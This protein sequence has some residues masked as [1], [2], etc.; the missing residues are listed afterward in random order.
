MNLINIEVVYATPEKQK[1]VAIKVEQGTTVRAAAMASG[2][3]AEFEGLDLSKAPLGIYGK[4]VKKPE[5]QEIK[6][7]ERIEVYRP[8]IADPKAA[9]LKRAAK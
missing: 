7:G 9:R 5:E 1:I 8:L 3:D 2:L 6:A 4:A